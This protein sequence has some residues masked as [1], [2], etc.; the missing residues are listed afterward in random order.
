MWAVLAMKELGR[1]ALF[2]TFGSLEDL[3]NDLPQGLMELYDRAW[4]KLDRS[5]NENVDL[6]KKI[7][8]WILLAARPLTLSK[9]NMVLA[10]RLSKTNDTSWLLLQSELFRNVATSFYI[11]LRR[12]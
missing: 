4:L 12:L 10:M 11:F 3:I 6:A 7:L 5:H 9:L 1:S 2:A 8:I